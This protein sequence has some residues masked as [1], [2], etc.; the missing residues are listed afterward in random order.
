MEKITRNGIKYGTIPLKNES[1]ACIDCDFWDHSN[2][3]SSYSKLKQK[4]NEGGDIWIPACHGRGEVVFRRIIYRC[5]E[6]DSKRVT[7]QAEIY[8]NEDR[9][10]PGSVHSFACAR[11]GINFD[12]PK[13]DIK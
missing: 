12:K 4:N 5:P 7:A 9:I 8:V 10:M 2:G 3:C 13:E 1:Q 6:C 11:C